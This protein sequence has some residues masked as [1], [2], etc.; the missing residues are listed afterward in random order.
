MDKSQSSLGLRI[1]GGLLNPHLALKE[2]LAVLWNFGDLLCADNALLIK[3]DHLSTSA[4]VPS[5]QISY[6]LFATKV[7]V[8]KFASPGVSPAISANG[9]SPM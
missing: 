2:S 1:H 5:E 9:F 3:C 7:M 8:G 4:K 6:R